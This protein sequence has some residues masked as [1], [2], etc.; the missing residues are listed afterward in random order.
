MRGLLSG[1]FIRWQVV[2]GIT[3]PSLLNSRQTTYT[4]SCE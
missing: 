3:P 4:V 2:F 1:F